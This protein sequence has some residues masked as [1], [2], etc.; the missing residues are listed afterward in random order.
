[1]QFLGFLNFLVTGN[2]FSPKEIESVKGEISFK[3]AIDSHL[4]WK[5]R[6]SEAVC[7]DGQVPDP[8]EAGDDKCCSLGRWISGAGGR[9]YGQFE[10]FADLREMHAEFHRV[11][12]RIAERQQQD[13]RRARQLLHEE[14]QPAS[15]RI[16]TR[17]EGL[18][19]LFGH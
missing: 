10:S 15:A 11:A 12:R 19:H 2:P 18:A 16:V 14:L 5:N 6:L 17:L 13:P 4:A 9:R 7:G 8:D 3:E 1:M